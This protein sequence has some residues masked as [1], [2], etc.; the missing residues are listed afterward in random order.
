M[1]IDSMQLSEYL[2]T[3]AL[4]VG[5]LGLASY[6]VVD[7]LKLFSWIDLAGFER[8]FGSGRKKN[9]RKWPLLH[10]SG[11]DPLLPALEAAYGTD[12]LELMKAQYRNGRSKGD[13]QRTLR[14]GIR[15]GFGVMSLQEITEIALAIGMD[16]QTAN[17]AAVALIIARDQR[18][19][20]TG[21]LQFKE[22]D[23]VTLGQRS[24]LARFE[25]SIDARID[26][27]LVL[28]EVQYVTQTKVIASLV[29][30]I[31]AFSVGHFLKAD[32]LVSFIIGISAVPLAPVAKDLAT[33]LQEAVRALKLR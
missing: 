23:P 10:H 18:P 13:L 31:I 27:A 1:T 5:G 17:Q 19:P 15:I 33:A 14:Q 28:A 4:A 21:E 20:A 26:A 3:V 8:L 11:L 24:A 6:G 29:A 2:G 12:S 9:G 25:T 22:V 30:L 7:G 32:Y 16:E